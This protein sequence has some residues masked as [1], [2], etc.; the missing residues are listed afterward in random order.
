MTKKHKPTL[1]RMREGKPGGGKGPLLSEDISLTVTGV[2]DVLFT[3]PP[4]SPHSA[5]SEDSTSD[6]KK[7]GSA[8][9]PSARS[10]PTPQPS[11]PPTG[12]TSPTSGTSSLSPP[13][14]A[15]GFDH[16]NLTETGDVSHTLQRANGGNNQPIVLTGSTPT[17]GAEA[18][19]AKTSASPESGEA[20]ASTTAKV[21]RTVGD[22]ADPTIVVDD[23]PMLAAN[24]MSDRVMTVVTGMPTGPDQDS[25]SPSSTS[26]SQLSWLDEAPPTSCSRTCQG[27][28]VAMP[29]EIWRR[30]SPRLLTSGMASRGG[31]WTRDTAESL[32][33]AEGCSSSACE[34]VMT[35]L[36]DILQPSVPQ[37][38][39]LSPRAAAGILRR[40]A[41]RG[42]DLPP[43]LEQALRSQADLPDDTERASTP[44]SMTAPSSSVRRLSPVE[45]ERLMGLPDGWTIAKDWKGR[46]PSSPKED[47]EPT[48]GPPKSKPRRRSPRKTPSSQTGE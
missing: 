3:D 40:A 5:G 14:I 28:S 34:C 39:S 46:T 32:N 10:N 47:K 36:T 2:Q 26:S 19:P 48:S 37:R 45:T 35:T 16:Y 9:S 11:S 44:P 24:P 15:T 33:G 1:L 25:P 21:I 42:R 29:V 23:L 43:H 4:T 8:P 30:S 41:R 38:Y 20:S 6:S 27:Y 17:S 18:S 7:P 12:P 13:D 22:Y 31:L